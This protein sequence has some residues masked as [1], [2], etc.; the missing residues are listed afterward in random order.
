[1]VVAVGSNG[2]VFVAEGTLFID[3]VSQ[4][5]V[6]IGHVEL[7][8]LRLILRLP[9]M[10]SLTLIFFLCSMFI[11]VDS[12]FSWTYIIVNLHHGQDQ[13]IRTKADASLQINFCIVLFFCVGMCGLDFAV[14]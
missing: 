6:Y 10:P 9:S 5:G 3:H 1:M 14:P 12:P 7:L 4:N 2:A 8:T 11:Y 13:Y